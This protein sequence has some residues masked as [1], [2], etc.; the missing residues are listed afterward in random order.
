MEENER[1]DLWIDL[2]AGQ[3]SWCSEELYM[4]LNN[5][6]C[7]LCTIYKKHIQRWFCQVCMFHLKNCWT[8]VDKK[9]T[10]SL[11]HW[12]PP[13]VHI[14]TFMILEIAVWQ[15]CDFVRSEQCF[16]SY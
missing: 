3:V 16:R 10:Y 5:I 4:M 14:V 12:R 2:A 13:Q 8:R 1:A 11:C 6:L 9:L 7:I 15:M